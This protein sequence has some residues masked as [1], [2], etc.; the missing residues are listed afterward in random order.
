M[1]YI[2]DANVTELT[3][4]SFSGDRMSDTR[5]KIGLPREHIT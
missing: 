1:M 5:G 2:Y 3:N 4:Y